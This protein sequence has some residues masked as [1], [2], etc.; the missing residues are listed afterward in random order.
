LR[1]LENENAK[2]AKRDR[3]T[4]LLG[5]TAALRTKPAGTDAAVAKFLNDSDAR[6]RADAEN[7]LS[8]VKAKNSSGRLRELLARDNDAVVRANAARALGS[9]EDRTAIAELIRAATDDVDQRVRIS[10][11]RSLAA[12]KEVSAADKLIDRGNLLLTSA[13]TSKFVNP[14]EATEMIEIATALGRIIPDTRNER[15]V[16]FLRS[17]AVLDKGLNP[18][19]TIARLLIAPGRGEPAAAL[20]LTNWHQYSTLAQAVGAFADLN[21]KD[22]DAIKMKAEAPEKLRPLAAAFAGA[23]PKAEAATIKAAPDVLRAYAKFKT[24]D[25]PAMLR[26]A[27]TSKDVFVRA[28]AAELMGDLPASSESVSALSAAFD[29]ALRNDAVFN[30]AALSALDSLY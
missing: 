12:M 18:E 21:T 5:L 8:R 15:A 9:A 30:D 13:R 4:V 17:L 2:G 19:I 28:T 27:L 11:I 24:P 1:V 26:T 6:I 14:P 22:A 7:T 29:N 3:L 16:D 25:L 20:T 10:A 23:D